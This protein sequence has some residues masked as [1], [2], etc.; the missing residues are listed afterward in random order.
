MLFDLASRPEYIDELR[1][2]IDQVLAENGED[3][4]ENGNPYINKATFAKLKRLDSFI[5][6]S[7]RWNGLSL[8]MVPLLYYL[9]PYTHLGI[10]NSQPRQ[11]AR[12]SRM[13]NSRLD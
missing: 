2:E 4:D 11:L 1:R 12:C 8:S 6:E 5:K 7:Q 10:A 9:L 13:S 3:L